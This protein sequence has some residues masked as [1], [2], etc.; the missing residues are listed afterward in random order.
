MSI[1]EI[2]ND[3][4]VDDFEAAV[5]R[6]HYDSVGGMY[7]PGFSLFQLREELLKRLTYYPSARYTYPA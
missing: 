5:R 2:T 6:I 4:L 1:S 3:K 7:D